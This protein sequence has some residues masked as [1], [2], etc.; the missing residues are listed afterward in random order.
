MQVFPSKR[1]YLEHAKLSHM[2][3]AQR[4]WIFCKN[5]QIFHPKKWENNHGCSTNVQNDFNEKTCLVCQT[6]F[7]SAEEC[8]SHM[9]KIHPNH[10]H[11][12]QICDI[13]NVK[14]PDKVSLMMHKLTHLASNE[15]SGPKIKI[16]TT[17]D[18]QGKNSTSFS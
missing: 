12:G 9:D 3:E 18:V 14:R 6:I 11:F 8:Y 15:S 1:A 2:L 16:I 4:R 17:K 10:D 5:C 13:C 7:E